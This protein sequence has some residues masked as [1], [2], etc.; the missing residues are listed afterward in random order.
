MS[1]VISDL[2]LRPALGLGYNRG[3]KAHWK[4]F[5]HR[6]RI[7]YS[8]VAVSLNSSSV[9]VTFFVMERVSLTGLAPR[10]IMPKIFVVA[11]RNFFREDI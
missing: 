4:D 1:W 5:C 9:S 7:V 6:F 10:D 2:R 8:A 3:Y 11:Q